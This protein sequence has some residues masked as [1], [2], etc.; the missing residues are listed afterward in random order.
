EAV[1]TT[2]YEPGRDTDASTTE[3]PVEK[4]IGRGGQVEVAVPTSVVDADGRTAGVGDVSLAYKHVLLAAPSWRTVVSGGLA[5]ELPTG[6]RRHGVG[7]GTTL[8][9][10]QLFSAHAFGPLV[11]QTQ[12]SGEL[13]ADP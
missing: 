12:V 4:R 8:V 1:A 9:T 7:A 10:P 11:A 5:V 2:A 13:P 3:R 6:N